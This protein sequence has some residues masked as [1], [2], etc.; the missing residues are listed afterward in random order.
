MK[1]ISILLLM[2]IILV[3]CG[4]EVLVTTGRIAADRYVPVEGCEFCISVSTYGVWNAESLDPWLKLDG[5]YRKG[6]GAV[7]VACLSNES[8]EGMRR[9][10]RVGRIVLRTYDECAC[11]TVRVFQ[12]GLAPYLH[13]GDMFV[14]T[15]GGVFDIPFSTNLTDN[16]RMGVTCKASASWIRSA[17]WSADGDS[18]RVEAEAGSTRNCTLTVSFTDSWGRTTDTQCIISQ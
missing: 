17:V 2:S 3:S 4:K 16:E 10:C 5:R 14:G 8:L 6:D 15:E 13:V 12:S 1:K 9:F 11:D 7:S 18:I